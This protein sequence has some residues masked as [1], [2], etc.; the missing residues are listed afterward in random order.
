MLERAKGA[1]IEPKAQP[2]TRAELERQLSKFDLKRVHSYSRNMLD[3]HAVMDLLPA[4]ARLWFENRVPIQ[5]SAIQRAIL[6]AIGLQHKV[7]R[8]TATHIVWS[9]GRRRWTR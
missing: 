1:V 6:L 4:L 8:T 3:Y 7:T 9:T 5:L 2:I